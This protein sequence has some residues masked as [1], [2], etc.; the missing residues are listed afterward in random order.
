M[1]ARALSIVLI[2][3]AGL[4]ALI[5]ALR[6]QPVPP[7]VPP[8]PPPA[9]AA[10]EP[11]RPDPVLGRAPEPSSAPAPSQPTLRSS[12]PPEPPATRT[13]VVEPAPSAPV[14]AAPEIEAPPPEPVKLALLDP[15]L[16]GGVAAIEN[17]H[18][19]TTKEERAQ[20]IATI[21]SAFSFGEPEDPEERVAFQA[22]K[23]ELV[24]LRD[25]LGASAGTPPR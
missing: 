9:A 10:T 12:A 11:A 24:W 23:D 13:A 4:G 6:S 19:N 15:I 3:A 25:H 17:R 1:S 22:L 16:P 21:E 18:R 14:P 8:G 2:L 20:R 5:W 7:A